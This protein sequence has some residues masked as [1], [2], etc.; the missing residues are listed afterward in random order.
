M[1]QKTKCHW[2]SEPWISVNWVN[3]Q[4]IRV[5]KSWIPSSNLI[6]IRVSIL[7][8][9][10]E[11]MYEVIFGSWENNLE[12]WIFFN[13]GQFNRSSETLQYL[14]IVNRNRCQ[15]YARSGILKNRKKIFFTRKCT[16]QV[17][18]NPENPKTLNF[19]AFYA[20]ASMSTSFTRNYIFLTRWLPLPLRDLSDHDKKSLFKHYGGVKGRKMCS[21]TIITNKVIK[22]PYVSTIQQFV[23]QV[24]SSRT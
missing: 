7:T 1:I 13:L 9:N 17:M 2:V 6:R 12:N 18:K 21:I 15:I 19:L 8:F 22:L 14:R 20:P 24:I 23:L 10:S 4:L 5:R 11:T 3:S 16:D